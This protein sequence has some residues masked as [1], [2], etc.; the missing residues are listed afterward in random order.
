MYR[1]SVD[2]ELT[3]ARLNSNILFGGDGSDGALAIS[4]GTT[5]IDLGG[6]QVVIKN[7]TSISITGTAKLAFSNPHANGTIVV[8]KSQGNVVLTSS[9]NPCIDLS[10]MGADGGAAGAVGKNGTCI[11]DD[12]AHYGGGCAA[13][14]GPPSPYG[15]AGTIFT[16]KNLYSKFTY[17]L[18]SKT[19]FVACG[20]GG[21]GG[22]AGYAGA[23]GGVGGKGGGALVIECGG[24]L[25]FT[26]TV[27]VAG[28]VGSAGANGGANGGGGGGGGGAGGMVVILYITATSTAGTINTIGG[29]GGA[30]G[31]GSNSWAGGGG[32]GAG[33]YGGVGGTGGP[34]YTAG[35]AGAGT[36]AG[37]GGGGG[38]GYGGGAG[39]GGAA[40]ASD[41]VL[42]AQNLNYF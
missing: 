33:A 41:N 8:L 32:G 14:S 22:N 9:T 42:C 17:N 37:G 4:S 31:S 18:I 7:Y 25:N 39:A 10:G 29:V 27:S 16:N 34:M 21:G 15:V 26:G 30:G 19:I 24:D 5:T 35:A 38:G 2:D 1:W 28:L 11:L 36:S 23:V 3:A 6:L 13:G 20:S 40:G 12:G